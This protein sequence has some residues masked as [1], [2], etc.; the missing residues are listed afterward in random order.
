MTLPRAVVRR[1][2]GRE[3]DQHVEVELDRVA[4]NLHVALFEDV[5]QADL[6]QFVQLGHLVHGE[7]AAVHARDQAEVQ[8]LLG[9]HAGAGGQLGRVDLADDVGELG[10]RRQPLGVA[11]LARPPGDRHIVL[12]H[13]GQHDR[14]PA[15]RDRL[16]RVFVDRAAGDRRDTES[17]RRG[18]GP[19]SA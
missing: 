15:A 18:S 5:E 16:I 2:V 10:A 13:L 1:R 12:R 7:D 11:L 14:L 9:G 6:H 8:R 3:E 17:P 19:A 4:A